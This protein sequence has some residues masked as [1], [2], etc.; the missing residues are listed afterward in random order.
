MRSRSQFG[1]ERNRFIRE[2]EELLFARV[3]GAQSHLYSLLIELIS[4]FDTDEDKNIKFTAR[5]ISKRT[6]LNQIITAFNK[7]RA[8]SIAKWVVER[9]RELIGLNKGYFK[10]LD[11]DAKVDDRVRKRI[12]TRLGYDE[13]KKKIIKNSF[14]DRITNTTSLAEE[15][16]QD[17]N[18]GIESKMSLSQFRKQFKA[19]F[20]NPDGL[21]MVERNFYRTTNDIFAS[22]DRAIA[23][24]YADEL[25]LNHAIYAGTEKNNTRDFC[26]ERLNKL[27][28]RE[29]I[30]NWANLDFQGKPKIYNPETDCG[31][32]NCRHSLNWIS[33]ELAKRLIPRL[34]L[35]QYN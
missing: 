33:D 27:Y 28:T 23:L 21:G 14:L 9:V 3:R 18:R 32:Y 8:V 19:K 20:T 31:G 17:F 29:E 15:I 25:E 26:K 34:G 7:S 5:N 13:V 10:H 2:K 11:S 22:Y 30:R 24:D 35:N 16:G 12:M 6:A 1:K 4:D